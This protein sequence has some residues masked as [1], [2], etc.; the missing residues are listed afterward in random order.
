VLADGDTVSKVLTYEGKEI[1]D[2]VGHLSVI[3]G[4]HQDAPPGLFIAAGPDIDPKADATGVDIHDITPTLLYALGM[5]VGQDMHGKAQTH[6]FK[7]DFQAA[8][9][10]QTIESWGSRGDTS[11]STGQDDEAHLEQLRALGYI[12]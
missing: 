2:C 6:L 12:D 9:P 7:G 10:L 3:T 1:T 8:H 4:S 11:V 5:P